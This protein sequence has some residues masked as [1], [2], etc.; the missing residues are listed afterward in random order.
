LHWRKDEAEYQ[1]L[2][3]RG[4]HHQAVIGTE[5]ALQAL[6]GVLA[7][8]IYIQCLILSDQPQQ[9]RGAASIGIM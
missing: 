6:Q 3:T 5:D 4:Q 7:E 2:A 8:L 1:D 9:P